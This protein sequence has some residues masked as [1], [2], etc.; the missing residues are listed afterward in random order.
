MSG[1]AALDL[2]AAGVA[3][4]R[5]D[6]AER[7]AGA[8]R[9][10]RWIGVAG[11]GSLL[12]VGVT[13][14]LAAPASPLLAPRAQAPLTPALQGVFAGSGLTLGARGCAVAIALLLAGYLAAVRGA[15]ALPVAPALAVVVVLHVAFALAPPLFSSDL[16]SYVAYGRMGAL[17]HLSPYL[18]GP[19]AIRGDPSFPFTGLTWVGTPSVYGPLFT[20]LSYAVAPL[21]VAGAAW[22]L[23]LLSAAASLG[24]VGLVWSC[25]RARG[26]APLPA[27]LLVGLNPLLLVW[28]VGGG[29]NDLLM[30]ALLLAGVRLALA[31]RA[32]TGAAAIVAAGAIKLSAVVVLPFLA[33]GLRGERRQLRRTLAGAALA[34]AALAGGAL[35]AFGTAPFSLGRTLGAHASDWHSIPGFVSHQLLGGGLPGGGVRLGLTLATVA[36]GLELARRVWRGRLDWLAGAG[37]ATLWTLLLTPVLLPWYVVWL[38]PLASLGDRRLR[39]A[40][41]A[42]TVLVVAIRLLDFLPA[43]VH[44][45]GVRPPGAQ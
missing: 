36:L 42:F 1:G 31:R 30:V 16:F 23:K 39:R 32:G 14:A 17:H 10:T 3:R 13:L 19:I 11:L 27:A 45:L 43:Y 18:H 24:C 21:G 8:S 44:T 34:A 7:A 22:T 37:W 35:V 2:R 41:L 9:W 33:L 40:A 6:D 12:V 20:G 28:A 38:T 15:A 4:G 26:L 29:H 5:A 25:A